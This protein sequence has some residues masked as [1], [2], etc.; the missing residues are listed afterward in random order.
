MRNKP[1]DLSLEQRLATRV[2]GGSKQA[3]LQHWTQIPGTNLPACK[4]AA[5][6]PLS[7]HLFCWGWGDTVLSLPQ[8]TCPMAQALLT[9]LCSPALLLCCS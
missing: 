9:A 2:R 6:L 1:Q 3:A 4:Q 8:P 7:P 5:G